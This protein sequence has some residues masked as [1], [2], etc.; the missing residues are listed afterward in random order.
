[1]T[2]LSVSGVVR[3]TLWCCNLVYL[4]PTVISLVKQMFSKPLVLK[5]LSEC[6]VAASNQIAMT[7]FG[8]SRPFCYLLRK[9]NWHEEDIHGSPE[10]LPRHTHFGNLAPDRVQESS[11]FNSEICLLCIPSAHR[12]TDE[13]ISRLQDLIEWSVILPSKGRQFRYMLQQGRGQRTFC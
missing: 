4:E 3:K 5:R 8:F 9:L 11:D 7:P 2:L 1:M 10:T 6:C 13:W 12:R